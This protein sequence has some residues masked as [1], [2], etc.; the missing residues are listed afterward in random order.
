[1][2]NPGTYVA[3]AE[4]YDF[5]VSDKNTEFVTVTFRIEEG[6]NIG[7]RINWNGYFT[8]KTTQRTL[9]SLRYCGWSGDNVA[10][11]SGI[12]KNL[13]QIVV[14][15]EEYQ[16]KTYTKIEWVNRLGGMSIKNRMDETARKAF[17]AKMKGAAMSV[18]KDLAKA[19][20]KAET[21]R[22]SATREPGDDFPF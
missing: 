6:E 7:E 22:P 13:V 4:S 21:E 2:I 16:G 1:M 15:N 11:L 10:D 14:K 8:E 18:S 19:A 20:P 17:A 3:K 12:E 9:E 5:G